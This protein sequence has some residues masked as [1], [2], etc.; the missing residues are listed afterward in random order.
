MRFSTLP[1]LSSHEIG[2]PKFRR[3]NPILEG[4]LYQFRQ[5]LYD[6]YG[7]T[8]ATALTRQ[9]LFQIPQGGN[10]TPAGGAAFVKT[11]WHT[12]MVLQGQLPS[13]Q[14]FFAKAISVS[15]RGDIVAA[16][17]VR[18]LWDTLLILNISGRPYL[19]ISVSKIPGGGGVFGFSSAFAGNGVPDRS[20]MFA[21]VGELGETIEQAQNF[22]VVMDPTRVIDAAS[23]A[24]YTTAAAAAG[25]TGVNALVTIDGLLNREVL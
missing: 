7:V 13:P 19:Q 16:D 22:N 6:Y 1:R 2:R 5:P 4:K 18:F 17:A 14:K 20:N 23:A 8:V 12:N 10:Y 11:E 15:V 24:T 9:L 21:F 25:G 3:A